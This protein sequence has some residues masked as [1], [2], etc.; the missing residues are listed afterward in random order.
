[1]SNLGPTTASQRAW[2]WAKRS[3]R[4]R[5]AALPARNLAFGP[6]E[7]RSS[8]FKVFLVYAC[9][10]LIWS[11][12]WVWIKIGLHGVPALTGAGI[13]FLLAGLLFAAWHAASGGTLR[14]SRVDLVFALVLGVVL[15]AAPF[16]LVYIAE[17]EVTSGL[18]AVLFGCLPLFAAVLADRMLP[19]EPLNRVRVLG[20]VISI[21][22][23]IVVFHGALALRGGAAA[24]AALAGLLI[25][26]AL[27]AFAQ[28]LM[29]KRE[30]TVDWFP[31]L[32][33]SSSCGGALLLA[34]G[35]ISERSHLKLDAATLGSIAYLAVIGTVLGF[36]LFFWLLARL[37][38]V[39]ISLQSLIVPVLA[40]VWGSVL[41]SEPLNSWVVA[42]AV[43]VG[44]GVA[45]ARLGQ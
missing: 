28:V 38:V 18:A 45:L 39:E 8:A 6:S 43:V 10:C 9:L 14:V 31:V 22:G 19:S 40:L 17:T 37:T 27:S 36:G 12:T 35:L 44:G 30:G 16:G 7:R 13:R 21:G 15:I 25:S 34:G 1:M 29:K 33:W 42:G 41:Y 11:S 4:L 32:A 23:L 3:A 26:A 5:R 20:I 24:V 2:S